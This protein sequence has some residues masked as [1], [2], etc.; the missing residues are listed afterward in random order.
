MWLKRF[1]RRKI[2]EMTVRTIGISATQLQS[3]LEEAEN[4]PTPKSVSGATELYLKQISRDFPDFC[5]SEAKNEISQY[6]EQYAAKQGGTNIRINRIS[7]S[8]YRKYDTYATIQ[9]QCST[10]FNRPE[11]NRYETRYILDYTLKIKDNGSA[12][13]VMKC[14]NCGAALQHTDILQCPYCDIKI[15]R[16]TILSWDVTSIK[17]K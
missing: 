2:N 15:I 13:A 12:S 7:I 9:Y 17:E 1:I 8:G 4:E 16:D 11:G 10:G 5:P 6:I 14:P 3:F